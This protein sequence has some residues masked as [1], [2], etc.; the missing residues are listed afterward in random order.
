M[1]LTVENATVTRLNSTGS[2]FNIEVEVEGSQ[3]PRKL[4]VWTRNRPNEGQRVNVTGVPSVKIEE[5]QGKP[6][7][8]WNINSPEVTILADESE[9]PF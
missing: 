7:A 9:A 3:Y 6:Y 8:Q 5:Y 1:K 2:G 4:T